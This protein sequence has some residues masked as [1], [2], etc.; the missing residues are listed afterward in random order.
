MRSGSV[1]LNSF[2]NFAFFEAYFSN[3]M[4]GTVFEGS[5]AKNIVDTGITC[6]TLLH[7]VR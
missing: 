7:R 4:E 5:E 6:M 1:W 3:Y 2:R